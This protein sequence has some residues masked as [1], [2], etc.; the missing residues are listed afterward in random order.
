MNAENELY[1]KLHETEPTR[2]EMLEYCWALRELAEGASARNLWEVLHH[3]TKAERYLTEFRGKMVPTPELSNAEGNMAIAMH[4]FIRKGMDCSLG[5]ILYRL[6]A[7]NKGI[8]V[9]YA[10]VKAVVAN[11]AIKNKKH[12]Y[13]LAIRASENAYST[14]NDNTDN[15]LMLSALRMWED[16]FE[17]F[18]DWG[19]ES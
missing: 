11:K 3:V 17:N 6:I 13:Q 15:L 4:T 14:G 19:K 18:L 7:E 10:F 5:T 2:Y 12:I 16:D 1:K 9:W 8:P